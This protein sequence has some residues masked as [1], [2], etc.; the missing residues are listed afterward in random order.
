MNDRAIIKRMAKAVNKNEVKV[1][2]A[3]IVIPLVFVVLILIAIIIVCA[4]KKDCCFRKKE[5]H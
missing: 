5:E 2:I 4:Y 3:T 1:Y